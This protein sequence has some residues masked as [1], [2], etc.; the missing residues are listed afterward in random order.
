MVTLTLL[1]GTQVNVPVRGRRAPS[2][3]V[4]APEISERT[5]HDL[6]AALR[7]AAHGADPVQTVGSDVQWEALFTLLLRVLLRKKLI[8]EEDLIEELKKPC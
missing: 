3:D 7:A 8:N 6:I 4:S 2:L 5:G 1:D